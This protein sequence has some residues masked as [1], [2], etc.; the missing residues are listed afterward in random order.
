MTDMLLFHEDSTERVLEWISPAMRTLSNCYTSVV[1][2][3]VSR[4]HRFSMYLY[5]DSV[6][7]RQGGVK[8]LTRDRYLN[9][10]FLY[11][12]VQIIYIV[13]QNQKCIIFYR[14]ASQHYIAS[15]RLFLQYAII[16]RLSKLFLANIFSKA[17]PITSL[18]LDYS[19]AL[20]CR[21]SDY[22]VKSHYS[23]EGP[24]TPDVPH[25]NLL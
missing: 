13:I 16:T 24:A 18:L 19:Y 20:Q 15:D 12:L 3:K 4:H 2:H 17:S 1:V 10:F 25:S 6:N 7:D 8:V 11:F 23:V 14:F 5:I 21:R 9:A 22:S